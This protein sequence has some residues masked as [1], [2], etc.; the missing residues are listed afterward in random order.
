M[1]ANDEHEESEYMLGLDFCEIK[2]SQRSVKGQMTNF[3]Y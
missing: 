1:V 3:K 2:R